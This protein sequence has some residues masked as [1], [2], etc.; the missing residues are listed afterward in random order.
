MEDRSVIG[1]SR[2]LNA[3][4]E[5]AGTG[6]DVLQRKV[7]QSVFGARSLNRIVNEDLESRHSV[8]SA[9]SARMRCWLALMAA[10]ISA[11]GR[12]GTYS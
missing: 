5:A 2:Y 7:R 11:S 8:T 10:S 12:G 3:G 4:E 6:L 1:S 9:S